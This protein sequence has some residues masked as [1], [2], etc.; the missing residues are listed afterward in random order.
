MPS[1]DRWSGPTRFGTVTWATSGGDR[2]GTFTYTPVAWDTDADQASPWVVPAPAQATATIT[3]EYAGSPVHADEQAEQ[4]LTVNL[5]PTQTSV[6]CSMPPILVNQKLENPDYDGNDSRCTITVEDVATEGT[7]TSPTGSI[8]LTTDVL[9]TSTADNNTGPTAVPPGPSRWKF[10]YVCTTLDDQAAFD[11]IQAD[12]AAN[13]GI[14]A[15]SS[16]AFAQ[17]IMRRPTVTTLSGCV[18]TS[19]G[20]KCT[21][22]TKEDAAN[23]GTDVLLEGG[24]VLLPDDD[25]SGC[26][27]LGPATEPTC[28]DFLVTED[29]LLVNVSVQFNPTDDVHLASTAS[30][31]V[32]RSG[33][34]DPDPTPSDA[35]G[36]D[37]GC[38]EGGVD[39]GT[40]IY[41]L[42][43]A[44][45]ALHA[46]QMGLEAGALIADVF[47]DPFT[48]GGVIVVAGVTIPISDIAAAIVSGSGIALEIAIVAMTTDLDGDGIPDAVEDTVTNTDSTMTDTDSDGMG[49]YDEI[50]YCGGYYGGSLRPDPNNPDSDEDGLLDGYE[51]A[52]FATDVC[53]GYRLRYAS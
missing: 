37:S 25:I 35:S 39:I 4:P 48:G 52:P 43:A 44:A 17:G 27:S 21:A 7:P 14:H 26:T 49:D 1:D 12:Y 18:S 2:I 15:D 13:D 41:N 47:P 10:D 33:E 23:A 42:N 31:T 51:L 30:E 50:G 45:V 40:M 29:A 19:S 22:T 20:V 38:G 3:A 9:G 11:T 16:G 36:C 6:M 5:R 8:A 32:D 34:F 24:F 28:T 46:I 53:V